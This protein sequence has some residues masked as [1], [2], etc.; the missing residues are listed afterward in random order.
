MQLIFFINESIDAE[1]IYFFKIV[2]LFYYVEVSVIFSIF[3]DV[4]FFKNF[5]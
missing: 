4:L 5:R 2:H 1:F 3:L